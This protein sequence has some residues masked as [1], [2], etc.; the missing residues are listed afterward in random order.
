MAG[1]RARTRR[2]APIVTPS[3]TTGPGPAS[4]DLLPLARSL[5][6]ISKSFAL[7]ALCLTESA[8]V[9]D[10]GRAVK[11][12][13]RARFLQALGLVADE[14]APLLGSTSRSVGELL[15]RGRRRRGQRSRGRNN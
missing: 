11:V 8:L 7:I 13:P 5:E 10:G 1:R 14:I 12:G 15:R 3:S 9:G 4:V 6:T 2:R